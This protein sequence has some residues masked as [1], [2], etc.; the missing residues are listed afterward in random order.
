MKIAIKRKI[1]NIQ[2]TDMNGLQLF[3]KILKKTLQN[4][5][6]FHYMQLHLVCQYNKMCVLIRC[7]FCESLAKLFVT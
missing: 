4:Q 7:T 5:E 1:M 6:A 2:H 3:M